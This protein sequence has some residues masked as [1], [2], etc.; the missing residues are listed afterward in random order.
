MRAVP[1]VAGEASGPALVLEAP[2][3]LW[4]GIDVERGEVSDRFH[5]QLGARI[6]G[7]VLV[8]P[9]GRGSSS[10]STILAEAVRLATAPAAL[11]LAEVDHILVVGALAARE[12]YGR[13]PPVVTL[14]EP[15]Y[16]RLRTGCQIA[17]SADGTVTVS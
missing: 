10:S 1:L 13:A 7:C 3:S 16:G 12:L 17:L 9:G 14:Q 8:M 6:T 11:V 15:H 2:L 4:G 5:P